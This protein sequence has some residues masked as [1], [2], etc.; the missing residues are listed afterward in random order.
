MNAEELRDLIDTQ[1][2][3]IDFEYHGKTG[4]ICFYSHSEISLSYNG[5]EVTVQSASAAMEEPFIDGLSLEEISE[6]LII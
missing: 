2:Q 6:E 4:S 1:A 3:D 5:Q